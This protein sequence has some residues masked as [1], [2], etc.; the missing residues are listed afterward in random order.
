VTD[1]A[2][3]AV[4]TQYYAIGVRATFDPVSRGHP[5]QNRNPYAAP[6]TNVTQADSVAEY[7]EVKI[8]SVQGRIGRVRYL[9]YSFG[10]SFLLLLLVGVAVAM[11]ASEPN[12]ALVIV[13]AGY[14]AIFAVQIMLTIQRAHDM[15]TTGW[16]SLIVF[17]PLAALVFWFVPGTKGENDYGLQ[18]PPNTG[19]VIAL[20][21][22]LPL[23][24]VIV[25][26]LAAI[27]I[28]A[29]QDYTIR[30]QVSEGLNLAAGPKVAVADAFERNLA[31]PADRLEAGMS[32]AATDTSGTYVESVD[33]AGGTIV[34]TYGAAANSMIAGRTLAL[35]PYVTADQGVA[36]RC[37]A[38]AAPN[39]GV[40]MNDG[41]PTAAVVT[42]IEP[43]Y[44]PSA[45]RP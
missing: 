9:G 26:I 15:N 28:P 17:V 21:C 45:C 41:A 23:G 18:P 1:L 40:P 6:Q 3:R 16:L 14:L 30:A 7:G 12:V 33:V 42:D 22:I 44:L 11:T 31:A 13:G 38:G 2:F 29:Y 8:F 43:R 20:A 24:F 39:G 37:G 10:L 25:G 36:W 19:G 32:A 4:V 27:A 34:V 5:M 35:Q